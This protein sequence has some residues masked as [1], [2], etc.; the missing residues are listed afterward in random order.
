MEE[1]FF[2]PPYGQPRAR[3]SCRGAEEP[4]SEQGGHGE[5]CRQPVKSCRWELDAS[6][7]VRVSGHAGWCCSHRGA[8]EAHSLPGGTAGRT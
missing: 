2:K 6:L 5:V 3:A 4:C 8:E 7:S 1:L